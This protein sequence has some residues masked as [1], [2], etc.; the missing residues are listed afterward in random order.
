MSTEEVL[1]VLVGALAFEVDD[2]RFIARPGEAVIVPAG[3]RFRVSNDTD[4]HALAWIVT[5]I[6]MTAL[7]L[8]SNERFSPPWAQ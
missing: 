3:A 2:E 4:E 1:R 7:M 6:G 8:D 5:P